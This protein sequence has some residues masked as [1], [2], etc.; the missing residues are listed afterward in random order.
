MTG[1]GATKLLFR[2]DA[3][4][5]E[6]AARVVALREGG[7]EKGWLGTGVV[8]DATVFYGRG[9]GQPGDAGVLRLADGGTV[10]VADAFYDRADG[11][12]VHLLA[13]PA[14]GKKLAAGTTVE[15]AID[16][17]RRYRLMRTHTALHV[18]Y[19]CAKKLA[20][21]VTGSAVGELRGRLDFDMPEP[22]DREKLEAAANELAGRDLALG[23]HWADAA[24]L[25][26]RPELTPGAPPPASG[27]IRL[28]EIPG[29]DLQ[30]CGGTHLRRTGEIGPLRIA[31]IEKKGKRNR[32]IVIE[33]QE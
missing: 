28:V 3:Y 14:D 11:A 4:L 26:G 33:L 17:A 23:F 8:A 20:E 9:G 30:A 12:L 2:E 24:E 32:R 29:A 5:R 15:C 25:Q 22:P 13:D 7:E 6:C 1:S 10:R 31:K 19:A 16:W 27:R 21:R 18:F